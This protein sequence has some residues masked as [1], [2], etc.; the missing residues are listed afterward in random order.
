M[1]TA[2]KNETLTPRNQC[3]RRKGELDSWLILRMR[4]L[5]RRDRAYR[6][7]PPVEYCCQGD[8]ATTNADNARK[9]NAVAMGRCIL[10]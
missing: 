1:F 8:C 6:V 2:M 5:R 7:R 9:M 10:T 3:L 4:A